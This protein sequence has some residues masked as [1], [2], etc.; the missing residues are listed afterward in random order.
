MSNIISYPKI[1]SLAPDDLMLVSD[2]DK[3]GMPTR[4]VSIAKLATY[5]ESGG[6]TTTSINGEVGN[7]I[8]EGGDNVTI[9]KAGRTFTIN[10]TGGS[11]GGVTK[12]IAGD[13]VT[14][15][16]TTGVGE[17][18]INSTATGGGGGDVGGSG[19]PGY[20][21]KWTASDNLGDS[22]IYDN[23]TNVGIGTVLPQRDFHVVGDTLLQGQTTS[24]SFVKSGGTSSQYLM[25]DGS[26]T[27][28]PGSN[29]SNEVAFFIA[30]SSINNSITMVY[31]SVDSLGSTTFSIA[32]EGSKVGAFIITASTNW[33]AGFYRLTMNVNVPVYYELPEKNVIKLGFCKRISDTQL[34]VEFFQ[35][36][37]SPTE[38][39]ERSDLIVADTSQ[40]DQGVNPFN[41]IDI[42][43]KRWTT[44]S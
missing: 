22:L 13:N 16:P 14:I 19:S 43:V 17:V 44:P 32:E 24:N 4:S 11:G 23:G 12:I 21:P 7:I 29:V 33:F 35:T 3:E 10:A 36:T 28:I 2:V 8:F 9:D 31:S 1:P 37:S 18:R 30:R 5:I 41:G 27:N 42:R 26:T 6:G 20:L 40:A 38:L 25:A 34:Q 39:L 15:S